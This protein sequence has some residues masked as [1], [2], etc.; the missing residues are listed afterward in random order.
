MD[1]CLQDKLNYPNYLKDKNV[2]VIGSSSH[3]VD[4]KQGSFIESH[5]VVV[6]IGNSAGI[7]AELSEDYGKRCDVLY[8]WHV[9]MKGTPFHELLKVKYVLWTMKKF[10]AKTDYELVSREEDAKWLREHGIHFDCIDNYQLKLREMFG[11]PPHG[12][13]IAINHLLSHQLRSLY[14]TGFSFHRMG[15]IEV[16]KA[17][18]FLI[19]SNSEVRTLN[20]SN[21]HNSVK[22][23]TE[24]FNLAAK[25][26]RIKM[27]DYLQNLRSSHFPDTIT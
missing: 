16:N 9:L 11:F 10:H 3:L 23:E 17:G 19:E 12:G 7:T 14:V 25:D 13:F 8:T 5:D 20:S 1:D 26:D 6:R 15:T 18:N 27:D 2:V 21:A 4:K 24:F 22:E